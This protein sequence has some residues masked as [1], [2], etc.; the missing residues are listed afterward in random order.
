MSMLD[1]DW[2]WGRLPHECDHYVRVFSNSDPWPS[3]DCRL[4][5]PGLWPTWCVRIFF[6][7]IDS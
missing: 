6:L 4:C 2:L 5:L 3:H 1:G 7:D